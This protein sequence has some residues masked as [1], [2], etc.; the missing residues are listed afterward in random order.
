MYEF[1]RAM[2]RRLSG[3]I[4]AT[5]CPP[6]HSRVLGC[7]ETTMERL[8]ADPHFCPR[9]ARRLFREIRGYFPLRA[10]EQVRAVVEHYVACAT[11]SFVFA[12]QAGVDPARIQGDC[13][14]KARDG[15]WC[16]RPPIPGSDY[17][18]SHK[19]LAGD[20]ALAA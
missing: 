6:A 9:P 19:H 14:G 1:S 8:A 7:C 4:D 3:E 18:P 12:L 20:V 17:C 16:S 13:R 15:S 2:Y 5:A 11:R 10:Q